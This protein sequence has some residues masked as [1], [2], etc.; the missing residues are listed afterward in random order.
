MFDGYH[1]AL[2]AKL[3]CQLNDICDVYCYGNACYQLFVDCIGT[4]NIIQIIDLEYDLPQNTINNDA[5]CDAATTYSDYQEHKNGNEVSVMR[6]NL[7]V[8]FI[9]LLAKSISSKLSFVL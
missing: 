5:A 3:I 1:S 2:N 7:A 8:H 6:T 9:L 4:C